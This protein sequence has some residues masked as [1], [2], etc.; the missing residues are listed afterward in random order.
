MS[1]WTLEQFYFFRSTITKA[2]WKSFFKGQWILLA[3]MGV[4]SISVIGWG[5]H[6]GAAFLILIPGVSVLISLV[7]FVRALLSDRASLLSSY[8]Q[9]RCAPPFDAQH[10]GS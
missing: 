4:G 5:F 9:S 2:W 10:F 6:E 3:M 1:T 8:Q 7:T